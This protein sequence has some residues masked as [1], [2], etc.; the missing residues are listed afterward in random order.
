MCATFAEKCPVYSKAHRPTYPTNPPHP[1]PPSQTNYH[2]PYPQ[3]VP[4]S[5][6]QPP[7]AYGS[8]LYN[9]INDVLNNNNYISDQPYPAVS[10][11][12]PAGPPV[13][14]T[15]TP[16]SNYQPPPATGGTPYYA[17]TLCMY[18]SYKEISHPFFSSLFSFLYCL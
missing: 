3:N 7:A 14:P 8:R 6:P 17:G 10:T 4:Y 5:Q 13:M 2:S 11:P 12:Y 15:P 1:Q 9:S 18:C 16:Q